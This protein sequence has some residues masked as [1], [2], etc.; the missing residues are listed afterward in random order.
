MRLGAAKQQ[1]PR[2]Q[3]CQVSSSH[4]SRFSDTW[5]DLVVSTLRHRWAVG[6]ADATLGSGFSWSDLLSG[7]LSSGDL[8]M[9]LRL[10]F[11]E[12]DQVF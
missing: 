10:N 12:G 7:T 1:H 9:F 2:L 11:K 5:S 4:V 8:V 6:S 3:Y